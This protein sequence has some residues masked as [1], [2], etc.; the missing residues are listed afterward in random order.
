[1]TRRRLFLSQLRRVAIGAAT[2]LLKLL[3]LLF[4]RSHLRIGRLLVVLVTSSACGD[5]NIRSQSTQSAGAGDVNVTGR[6]FHH[7][8]ALTA[9]M[10]EPRRLTR[11]RIDRC[12][13]SS[14][15]MTPATVVAGRFLIFPM[16]VEARVMTVRHCLEKVVRLCCGVRLW[17]ERREDQV[18]VPLMANRAVVVV[19]FLIIG[20]RG[21]KK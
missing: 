14:R 9:F 19:G 1:M 17:R 7:V 20:V 2:R 4:N 12:E 18:V 5:W 3:E 11:R 15:L 13:G 8:L 10:T 6:A 16:T 21:A